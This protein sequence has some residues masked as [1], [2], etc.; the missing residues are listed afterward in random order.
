MPKL[1]HS[2]FDGTVSVTIKETEGLTAGQ[3]KTLNLSI[4]LVSVQSKAGQQ[5]GETGREIIEKGGGETG[6]RKW[7]KREKQFQQ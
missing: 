4:C 3:I 7:D 1:D 5:R 6:G 2:V